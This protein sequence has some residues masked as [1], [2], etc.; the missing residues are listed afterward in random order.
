MTEELLSEQEV[1]RR[2]DDVTGALERLSADLEQGEELPVVL[3]R[4]CRQVV[5]AV[6]DTDMASITLL[7]DG[8]PY[9]ATSTGE[10]ALR[11]DQAQYEAD[12][13]PCLEAART[14]RIQRVKV[15][16]AARRWPAFTAA[17]GDDAVTSYLSAPLFI[18][19]QYHGS[20]NLYGTDGDGFDSLDAAL[21]ELYTTAAEAALRSARSSQH[22]LATV[23]ELRTALTSRAVIDQAKGIL[24][25]LYRISADEAFARLVKQ[26]QDTNV[27]LRDVAERFV[28]DAVSSPR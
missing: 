13:G 27:K 5:R 12:E 17:A 8:S 26:S 21:L 7:D 1:V 25:V 3:Q 23:E 18:E 20:L 14:G 15:G 16:E 11:I 24:M 6:P 9:T 28:A 10:A 22:A 4:L 2:V 19:R